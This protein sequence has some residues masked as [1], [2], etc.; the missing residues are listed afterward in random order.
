[1]MSNAVKTHWESVYGIKTIPEPGK[2]W[3]LMDWFWAQMVGDKTSSIAVDMNDQV[4]VFALT[5]T[6]NDNDLK[7]KP[8]HLCIQFLTETGRLLAIDFFPS[9]SKTQR[10]FFEAVQ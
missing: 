8:T 5:E 4:L 7:G 9:R 2:L 1:M 10:E 3:R 6:V